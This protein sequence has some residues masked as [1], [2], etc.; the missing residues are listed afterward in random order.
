MSAITTSINVDQAASTTATLIAA[1]T[2]YKV[3]VVSMCLSVFGGIGTVKST[4]QDI[5]ANT[6][7]ATLVGSAT[8]PAVY[9][10][11]GEAGNPAFSTALDEGVE[12]VTG[13]DVTITGWMTYR[14]EPYA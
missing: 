11:H 14:R 7:R 12:L 4:L 3:E 9:S 13:A 1:V 2:G 10:H 6:V 8:V 5:T